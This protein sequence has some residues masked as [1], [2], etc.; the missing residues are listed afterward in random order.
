LN[1]KQ[2]GYRKIPK[3]KGFILTAFYNFGSAI[4][5]SN[6]NIKQLKFDISRGDR[7]QALFYIKIVDR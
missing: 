1:K 3:D 6:E 4:S 2:K 5:K 7:I